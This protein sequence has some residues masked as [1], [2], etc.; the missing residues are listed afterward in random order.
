MNKYSINS[1]EVGLKQQFVADITQEKL[2]AFTLLSGDINPL[3]TNEEY[4]KKRG[5]PGLVVYGMMT[6]SL[7]STLVGVYLPGKYA[8][9]QD[10]ETRFSRP[11]FLGDILSIQG[12]VVEVHKALKRIEIKATIRNQHGKIVSRARIHSGI[13]EGE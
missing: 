7:Y 2:N 9:L 6:A 4:A 8:L 3:H 12:E 1:I 10:I 11:V 5:H 13:D